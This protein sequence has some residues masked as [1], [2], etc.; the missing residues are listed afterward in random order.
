MRGRWV[1]MC[2]TLLTIPVAVS[3]AQLAELQPG[4]R[5][6]VLAPSAVAGKLTGVVLARVGDSVSISRPD[7]LPVTVPLSAFTS[8]EISRGRSRSR[9]AVKGALWGGGTF[10]LLSAILPADSRPCK[11]GQVEPDCERVSA[12]TN[13]AYGGLGGAF[14]GSLIGAAIGPEHWVRATLP[15]RVAVTTTTSWRGIGL[16]VRVTP[17]R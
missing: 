11:E 16:G 15:A 14:L 12:G 4:T 1:V 17:T 10:L 8:L 6:R 13:L 7:A 9:G 5:V 3:H 2:V